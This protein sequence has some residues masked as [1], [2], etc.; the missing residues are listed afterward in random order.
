[1]PVLLLV[2]SLVVD[3]GSL[4]VE[5]VRLRSAQDTALVDA[6]TEVDAANY[7]ATGRL[8]IDGRAV[9]VF[10]AYLA[11]NL[12]SMRALLV[13]AGASPEAVAATAEVVILNQVPATDPFTGV[14]V[15][16]PAICSRLHAPLRTGLLHLAGLSQVQTLT[17]SGDAQMKGDV[18]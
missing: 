12:T 17:V 9:D 14:T 10:R 11:A 1:M 13:D 16:R 15:D 7:A 3:V 5:R 8:Q 18:R 2:M 6:V 4:Q